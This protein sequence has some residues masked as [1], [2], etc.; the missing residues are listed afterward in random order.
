LERIATACGK[1]NRKIPPSLVLHDL[2][3]YLVIISDK[4]R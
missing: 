4:L 1:N 2:L 3:S